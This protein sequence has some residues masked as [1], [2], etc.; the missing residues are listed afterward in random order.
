VVSY[1]ID[2]VM[3]VIMSEETFFSRCIVQVG[4]GVY[5]PNRWVGMSVSG[6]FA[7][8]AGDWA[9]GGREGG[10]CIVLLV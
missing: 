6:V 1:I 7:V 3:S 4:S 2:I 5:R 9:A 10:R 8:M